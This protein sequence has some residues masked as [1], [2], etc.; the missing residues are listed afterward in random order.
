MVGNGLAVHTLQQ[1]LQIKSG[2]Q[3]NY[4]RWLIT[5]DG[6]HV[7]IADFGL[8]DVTLAFKKLFH[9]QIK[10]GFQQSYRALTIGQDP[11]MIRQFRRDYLVMNT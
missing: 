9:R 11:T 4:D 1:K 3:F 2:F 5:L 10:F 6:K 8:Y 7:T